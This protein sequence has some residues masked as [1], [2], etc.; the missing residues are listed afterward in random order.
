MLYYIILYYIIL[1][2][3]IYLIKKSKSELTSEIESP[4]LFSFFFQ[5]ILSLFFVLVTFPLDITKTRLQ[6]QGEHALKTSKKTPATKYRG[7]TKTAVGIGNI[8]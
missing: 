1:Y 3:I 8:S 2:Y 4:K 7:M 5:S 6:V